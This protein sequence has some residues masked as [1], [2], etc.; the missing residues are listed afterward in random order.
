MCSPSRRP[1]CWT[2]RPITANALSLREGR[3]SQRPSCSLGAR[4]RTKVPGAGDAA[5]IWAMSPVWLRSVFLGA[6][7]ALIGSTSW[8]ITGTAVVSNLAYYGMFL[9]GPSLQTMAALATLR[10]SKSPI[11]P[12]VAT[13]A[14]YWIGASI[15]W[16]VGSNVAYMTVSEGA[17][18]V[19]DEMLTWS[20]MWAVVFTAVIAI[21]TGSV[22]AW[23]VRS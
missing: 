20:W 10:R 1:R 22:R 8:R 16:V 6:A 9:L 18:T 14:A 4:P 13:G 19:E 23:Q 5:D 3:P 15:A 7:I 17:F 11:R 21:I 12:I 2:A